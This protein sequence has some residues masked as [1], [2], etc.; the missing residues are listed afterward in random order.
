MG[1]H[2]PE[3]W[4]DALASASVQMGYRLQKNA[5]VASAPIRREVAMPNVAGGQVPRTGTIR[6]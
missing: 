3:Y 4:A 5:A 6:I 2:M 1:H